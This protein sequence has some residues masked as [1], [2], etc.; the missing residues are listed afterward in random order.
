MGC[1]EF[2]FFEKYLHKILFLKSVFMALAYNRVI[3]RV[4]KLF[5]RFTDHDDIVGDKKILRSMVMYGLD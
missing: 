5:I 1:L 4:L 3:V 2:R